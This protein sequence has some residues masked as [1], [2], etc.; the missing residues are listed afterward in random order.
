MEGRWDGGKEWGMRREGKGG[1]KEHGR[2]E[3]ERRVKYEGEERVTGDS[4]EEENEEMNRIKG[5]HIYT[6]A[7][8][9]VLQKIYRIHKALNIQIIRIQNIF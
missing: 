6:K 4:E 2:E 8:Q 7:I 1:G 9:C 3:G 5:E